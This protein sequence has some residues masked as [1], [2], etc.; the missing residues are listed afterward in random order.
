MLIIFK[1]FIKYKV[2]SILNSTNFVNENNST[3]KMS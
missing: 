2:F 1:K 3:K